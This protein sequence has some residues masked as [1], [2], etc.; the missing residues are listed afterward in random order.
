[1]RGRASDQ[2]LLYIITSQ[3]LS[4]KIHEFQRA[5]ENKVKRERERDSQLYYRP[6]STSVSRRR[7]YEKVNTP[8]GTGEWRTEGG[9]GNR[10]G[11]ESLRD[12]ARSARDKIHPPRAP[13]QRARFAGG[14]GR[15]ANSGRRGHKSD[16]HPK[17]PRNTKQKKDR[18]G[19]ATLERGSQ[20]GRLFSNNLPRDVGEGWG[21]GDS[22]GS[23]FPASEVE[24]EEKVVDAGGGK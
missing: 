8:V 10:I 5:E 24:V 6:F 22:Q 21:V 15:R 11:M 12:K 1:M 17:V 4:R 2:L 14:K 3:F 16:G 19:V 13:E 23:G 9:R 7:G 20:S 18:A